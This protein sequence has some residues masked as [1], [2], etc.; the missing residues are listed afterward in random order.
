MKI[1]ILVVLFL[2][3]HAIFC[4]ISDE[5]IKKIDEEVKTENVGKVVINGFDE[6]TGDHKIQVNAMQYKTWSGSDV[7]AKNIFTDPIF[8]SLLHLRT[9]SATTKFL[10]LQIGTPIVPYGSVGHMYCV[11]D[12]NGKI[13]FILDNGDKVELNQSSNVDCGVSVTPKYLLLRPELEKLCNNNIEKFRIYYTEHY[14]DYIVKDKRK[15]LI[16]STF[17]VFKTEIDKFMQ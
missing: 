14:T 8:L 16:M 10:Q 1:K 4:Q 2:A 5:Y 6:F 3:T 13:I 11:S 17:N 9:S 15:D 12:R 7:I